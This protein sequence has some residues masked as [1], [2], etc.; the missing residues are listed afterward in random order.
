MTHVG[1]ELERLLEI[2]GDRHAQAI[3]AERLAEVATGLTPCDR[4]LQVEVVGRDDCRSEHSPDGAEG[5]GEANGEGCGG[6]WKRGRYCL[7]ASSI[8]SSSACVCSRSSCDCVVG[9]SRN[10]C[11]A[12]LRSPESAALTTCCWKL[13]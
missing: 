11:S 9:S 4:R 7:L 6:Y 1:S 8:S 2:P 12:A 3:A 10:A 13:T 5:T